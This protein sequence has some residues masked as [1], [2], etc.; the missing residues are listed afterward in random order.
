MSVHVSTDWAK[1]IRDAR[2]DGFGAGEDVGYARA[3][4]RVRDA[5]IAS[6]F[7]LI[8]RDVLAEQLGIELPDGLGTRGFHDVPAGGPGDDTEE[9]NP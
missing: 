5:L 9:E 2:N 3:M 8:D 7:D 4:E 1:A 6:D